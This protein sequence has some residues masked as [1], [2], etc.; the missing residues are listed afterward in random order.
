MM[1][2]NRYNMS[3]TAGALLYRESLKVARL[4]EEMGDWQAVRAR[5]MD[6][7]LLQMRTLSA[8]KRVF[9]EV[10]SRLKHLT[11]AQLALLRTGTRQEQGHLLWLA[12]CKRYRFIYDFA[13]EVMREKFMRL[14]FDLPYDAYDVFFN[15]KAEWHPE[16]EGVADSTRKKLRQ[17]LFKM[18][19][20]AGLLTQDD[21]ILPAML[22]PREIDVI[23]TD[24]AS[25]LRVF[26]ISPTEVEEWLA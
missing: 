8:A 11:P 23:A 15:N 24:S 5:V 4:Y 12:I 10:A 9:R 3:F 13:V 16:V 7:N 1:N 22:T 21:Q 17:V 14:D 26:P 18:M 6:D 25:Y 19:R 2:E 20:E